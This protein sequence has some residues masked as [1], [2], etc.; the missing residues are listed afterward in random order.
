[1]SGARVMVVGGGGREHALAWV[2]A[3]S[4]RVAELVLAPGNA[5][6]EALGP[7]VPVPQ[8]LA[9][10]DGAAASAAAAALAAEAERRRVDLVV[11]GPEAPLAAGLVDALARRGIAAFGPTAAAA[12]LETSKAHAKAFMHRHGIPTADAVTADDLGAAHAAVDA[13]AELAGGRVVVKASGLAAG[14]GVTVAEDA[15]A[16]HAAVDGAFAGGEREVVVER[17]LEGDE[18]SLLV[19]TDGRTA[20]PLPLVEDHKA[21]H[22]GDTGPMTGGMGAVAPVAALGDG[23]LAVVME[24]VVT[25][26]LAGLRDEGR[27]FVGTLFL[28]LMLTPDGPRLLE[29]NVRFGDPETQA[30]LPLLASDAFELLAAAAGGRLLEVEPRWHAGACACVVMAAAGYPGRTRVGD[31]IDL[32]ADL[33]AEVVVFHAGTARDERG[34][35]VTAGGRVLGV[36]AVGADAAAA[37]ARAYDAVARVRFDGAHVRRDIGRRRHRW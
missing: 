5:G 30:L 12:R 32:P 31:A 17:F 15:A 2:L 16:G 24:R 20:R 14:K 18:V 6:T 9:P 23:G 21:A 19:V 3:R 35:L 8:W 26:T 36:T 11:V 22:D 27:P 10:A 28:G 7:H 33:G 37:V 1:M 25:P 13:L 34:R 29:Y 4:P